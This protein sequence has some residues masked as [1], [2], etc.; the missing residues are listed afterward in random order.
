[1]QEDDKFIIILSAM[2]GCLIIGILLVHLWIVVPEQQA[3][4]DKWK[5]DHFECP[6][7]EVYDNYGC[8]LEK[9]NQ[10]EARLNQTGQ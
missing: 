7:V 4:A 8:L 3:A 1:M 5:A 2:I 10:L 6:N 9:I